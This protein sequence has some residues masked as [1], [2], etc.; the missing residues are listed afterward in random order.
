MKT[1]RDV[2]MRFFPLNGKNPN[3]AEEFDE[4]S[5]DYVRAA[6]M[7]EEVLNICDPNFEG[8]CIHQDEIH[9]IIPS[10]SHGN[11]SVHWWL[12]GHGSRINFFP[13]HLLDS[14]DFAAD[15]KQWRHDTR[16]AFLKGEIERLTKEVHDEYQIRI[17]EL[18]Q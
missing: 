4:Q 1:L 3:L 16:I 5:P 8:L 9:T 15:A 12:S 11:V 13:I 7:L 6:E 18:T 17:R 10:P 14:E 2:I